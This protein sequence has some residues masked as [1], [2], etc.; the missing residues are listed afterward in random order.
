[1]LTLAFFHLKK[2]CHYLSIVSKV[3]ALVRSKSHIFELE[4]K[5]A[6]RAIPQIT[7]EWRE[8]AQL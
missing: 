3:L 8:I 4:K 2:V 1:M 7:G 6:R 5:G